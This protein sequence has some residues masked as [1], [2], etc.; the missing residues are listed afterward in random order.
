MR[1]ERLGEALTRRGRSV[2]GVGDNFSGIASS[3]IDV[4][5]CHAA[6]TSGGTCG[7]ERK[8]GVKNFDRI[9]GLFQDLHDLDWIGVSKWR[10]RC[11]VVD[12]VAGTNSAVA[13]RPAEAEPA[14]PSGQSGTF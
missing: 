4:K 13:Y 3:R 12:G 6:T 8:R 14:V 9:A 11:F 7:A 5:Q 10:I 1:G 2:A